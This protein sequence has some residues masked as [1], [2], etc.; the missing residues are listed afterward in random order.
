[1]YK[2]FIFAV[3]IAKARRRLMHLGSVFIPSKRL[4]PGFMTL[5]AS[6]LWNTYSSPSD[7]RPYHVIPLPLLQTQPV[8]VVT[9]ILEADAKAHLE[10][11]N[12]E[13]TNVRSCSNSTNCDKKHVNN[14][15][16]TAEFAEN[17]E[18]GGKNVLAATNAGYFML[19][20]GCNTPWGMQIVEGVV[21]TEPRTVS[22]SAKNYQG[23]F[24]VTKDGT[25]IISSSASDYNNN[26]KGKDII[27]Y[28][29]GGRRELFIEDGI[30]NKSNYSDIRTRGADARLSIGYNANGDIVIIVADGNDA[31]V[32]SCPGATSNDMAQIFMDLDMD[33]THVLWLDG[34]GSTTV[35]V[36][37]SNGILTQE[38]TVNGNSDS[39]GDGIYDNQRPL[40]DI[41]AIVAD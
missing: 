24:G 4:N 5:Q 15:L 27:Y 21:K 36:E 10:V 6:S 7:K 37:N 14:K 39:N 34:G 17:M 11:Q 16:T 31:N 1:M 20:A 13:Y 32:T 28:G 18:N 23:W 41:I 30:F 33:I 2:L 25:P 26:Y 3:L 19:S 22:S 9:I 35:M 38:N 40:S 8:Q 29:V 12:A